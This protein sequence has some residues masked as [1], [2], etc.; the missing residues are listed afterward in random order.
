MGFFTDDELGSLKITNMILHV[1]GGGE[2]NPAPARAVE[3][4]QFFLARIGNTDV[5]PVYSFADTSLTKAEVQRIFTSEI[6]FEDG[7][8]NLA[9]EFSKLHVKTSSD[10][11][12]FMFELSVKDKNTKLYSLIKYDYREAIEQPDGEHGLLRRIVHAFIADKKAIQKS[13]IIRVK[14]GV[15]ETVISTTDRMKQAPAIGDYFATFLDA[16]RSL[17]DEGLN[18]KTID[19]VRNLL[20]ENKEHLPNKDVALAYGIA[21]NVLRDRQE[22]NEEAIIDAVLAAAGNPQDETIQSRLRTVT[23]R[24]IRGARLDGIGFKP[25]PRILKRPTLRKVRTVEGVTITYPEQDGAVTVLRKKTDRG[26]E[27]ITIETEKVTEDSVVG[28]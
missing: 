14:D 23:A 5:S 22:I 21:K 9:R 10:G 12:L 6:S 8:Q 7:A 1:V 2:F 11:A 4:E 27:T 19:L 17:S 24:K 13:A 25:N 26:G 3:H 20:G 18:Q 28:N 15:A 16:T